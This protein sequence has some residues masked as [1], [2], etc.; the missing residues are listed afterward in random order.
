[1]RYIFLLAI[2]AALLVTFGGC[3]LTKDVPR[4]SADEVT[5]IAQNFTPRCGVIP[6]G[7]WLTRFNSSVGGVQARG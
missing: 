1:M 4:H 7:V 2:I 5:T 6:G 3:T